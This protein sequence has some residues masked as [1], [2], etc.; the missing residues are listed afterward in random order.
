MI[1]D[2]DVCVSLGANGIGNLLSSIFYLR[3]SILDS[4]HDPW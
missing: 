3:S 1:E 4:T 2:S